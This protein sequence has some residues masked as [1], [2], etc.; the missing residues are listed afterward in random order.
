MA[1]DAFASKIEYLRLKR[2]HVIDLC[3]RLQWLIT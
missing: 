1:I 3:F 2:W